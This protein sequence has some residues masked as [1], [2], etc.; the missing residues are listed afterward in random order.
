M[1]EIIDIKAREVLDS[2]GNPT[3]ETEI[4]TG[5]GYGSAIVPSGA[6]T[7]KHEALELR[8]KNYRY[9]GKGVLNAVRNVNE[10]I[11]PLLI[12]MDI[13]KQKEIDRVM[14]EEDGTENKGN[15]GANAILSVSLA[16]ARCAADTLNIPL[17]QYIGGLN[18]FVLPVPM[19][20][21][22]NGGEHAGNELDFQEFM[23]MPVGAKSFSEALRVCAE[24]YH[25]MKKIIAKKYGKSSTNVGDEG[26]YAPPM[27]EISEPL[28]IIMS[29]LEELSY[30]DIF[31][32][33]L[34]TA[35]STFYDEKTN[36]YNA[37]GKKMNSGE[38]IDLFA[39]VCSKYPII[40]IE[41]PMAED[42]FEGFVEIT[43]KL[44]KKIQIVGDDLF[45][46]NKNRLSTGI[47]KGAC[48]SLLLKVNQIGSLTEAIDTANLAYRNGY[49]VVVSH[50]SG[51]TEDTMIADIAV[52]I[53]SGQIKTGAP[54]RSER[55]AKY[56]RLLRIEEYLGESSFYAGKKFKIPF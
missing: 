6:S 41:D 5:G 51:E 27:K 30:T 34:D 21:V 56:N 54:S 35:S 23:I 7:G 32:I 55:C 15:F 50:R 33:A 13:R 10:T 44:G 24:V 45:V 9:G 25:H 52:G 49:S 37:M 16:A 38:L 29:T 26:G 47:E 43:K 12:G 36:M 22:I 4:I 3:I 31:K 11:T 28:E 19:M 17:Y 14:I 48:N 1:F 18:T 20:N 39:N 46:T 8:D 2:R 53:S 42:D 40:S